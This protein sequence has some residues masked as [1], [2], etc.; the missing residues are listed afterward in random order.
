MGSERGSGRD[1]AVGRALDPG[2][3]VALTCSALA[4]PISLVTPASKHRTAPLGVL[5]YQSPLVY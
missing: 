2:V 3:M 5:V 4:M 1:G